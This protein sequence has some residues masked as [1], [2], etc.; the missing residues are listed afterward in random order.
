MRRLPGRTIAADI[1]RTSVPPRWLIL[2]AVFFAL[3]A[4]VLIAIGYVHLAQIVGVVAIM[5]VV[6]WPITKSCQAVDGGIA[7]AYAA[8]RIR[9]SRIRRVSL[10]P[11][12]TEG[13]LAL[14]NDSDDD[15]CCDV[16]GGTGNAR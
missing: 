8:N 6:A 2:K 5:Q 13:Q 9:L 10:C 1:L 11:F 16:C 7:R 12:C 14:P 15:N 3:C 4:V